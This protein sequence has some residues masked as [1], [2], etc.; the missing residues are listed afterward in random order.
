MSVQ[1]QLRTLYS[2]DRQLQALRSRVDAATRR[3]TAT[4]TRLEQHERQQAE[5]SD[6]LKAAQAKV[7]TQENEAAS[8]EARIEQLRQTMSTV[9]SNKEY[10]A[11]LVEVNTQKAEKAKYEDA[12]LNEMTEVE[13]LQSRLAVLSTKTDEQRVLVDGA[14]KEVTEGE[15][16]I[17]EQLSELQTQRDAAAT[18]IADDTMGLYTKLIDEFDG[19]A[20]AE[21][22]EQDRRRMEY[23]CGAC[24]MSLPIQVVNATLT[25]SITPV[26]CSS[27]QRILHA[28]PELIE[29]LLPKEKK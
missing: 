20:L 11:L 23:T 9:R 28:S 7:S 14:Q 21:I 26:Q 10:S 5:L 29:A 27:C 13:E 15:S 6:Q 2:V 18:P 22:E 24:F 17:S 8:V 3:L 12:A 19:E 4:Q 16:E 1:D 25:A